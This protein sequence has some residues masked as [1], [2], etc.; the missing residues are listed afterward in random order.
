M[1]DEMTL[2]QLEKLEKNPHYK[3]SQKQ[4]AQLASLR[5]GQFRNNPSFAKHP[6]APHKDGE[7]TEN[8]KDTDSN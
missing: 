1:Q 3:L 8:G 2:E 4:Q 7:P 5:S 6:T